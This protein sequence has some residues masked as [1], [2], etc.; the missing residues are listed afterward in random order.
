MNNS[1]TQPKIIEIVYFNTLK[2][3]NPSVQNWCNTQKNHIQFTQYTSQ[4]PITNKCPTIKHPTIQTD[5]INPPINHLQNILNRLNLKLINANQTIK[6]HMLRII[7]NPHTFSFRKTYI[8]QIPII[9]KNNISTIFIHNS[10][11]HLN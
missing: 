10:A 7:S 2:Y 4:I 11:S 6:I 3:P 1:K 9:I 5:K 8:F